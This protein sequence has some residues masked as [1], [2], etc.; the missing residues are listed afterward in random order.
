MGPCSLLGVS[1][2]TRMHSTS[3]GHRAPFKPPPPPPPGDAPNS[4]APVVV[5]CRLGG[6]LSNCGK[7]AQRQR[8]CILRG[9]IPPCV[10]LSLSAY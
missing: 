5:R 9:P 4:R 8:D 1:G 10:L 7:A 3:S 6:V 2:M